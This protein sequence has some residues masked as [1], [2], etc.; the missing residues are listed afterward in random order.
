MRLLN[1]ENFCRHFEQPG[2]SF[3]DYLL[4]LRATSAWKGFSLKSILDQIIEGFF[5]AE[6]SDRPQFISTVH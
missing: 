2:K 5:D 1:V 3:N 4:P 6:I